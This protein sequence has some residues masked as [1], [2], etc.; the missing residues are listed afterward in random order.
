MKREVDTYMSNKTLEQ[1]EALD[2]EMLT[3]ADIAPILGSDPQTI[4][5]QAQNKP[6]KL[7]FP[8]ILI[9]NR[10]KIPKA[11]FINFCLG[12]SYDPEH[13]AKPH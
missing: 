13:L 12:K 9:G 1:I 11:A 5:W 6:G 8:I 2:K 10:V 7:G 4:R 3:P